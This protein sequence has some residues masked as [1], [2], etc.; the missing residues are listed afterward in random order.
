MN[1]KNIYLQTNER[2]ECIIRNL[3]SQA[4]SFI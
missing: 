4:H 3:L 1:N 2:N